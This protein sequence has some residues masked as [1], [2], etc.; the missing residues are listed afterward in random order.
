MRVWGERWRSKSVERWGGVRLG[1]KR[2]RERSGGEGE[3]R[4]S[5]EK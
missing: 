1:S 5:G 3:E 2:E 4:K